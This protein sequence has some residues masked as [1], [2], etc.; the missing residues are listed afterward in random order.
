MATSETRCETQPWVTAAIN[1]GP[2]SNVLWLVEEVIKKAHW[3]ATKPLIPPKASTNYYRPS[4]G[5]CLLLTIVVPLSAARGGVSFYWNTEPMAFCLDLQNAC[6]DCDQTTSSAKYILSAKCGFLTWSEV[7]CKAL[8]F[9]FFRLETENEAAEVAGI[10]YKGMLYGCV[11]SFET[12]LCKSSWTDVLTSEIDQNFFDSVA[13]PKNKPAG[14]WF[15]KKSLN[16]QKFTLG[17]D[18][19]HTELY[20]M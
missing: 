13:E 1:K 4:L 3:A 11:S 9:F 15:H 12:A 10:L 8:H 14:M 17:F 2:C 7:Y 20:L 18:I 5:H 19:S 6:G 16:W